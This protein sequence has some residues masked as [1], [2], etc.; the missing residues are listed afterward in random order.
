MSWRF[1]TAAVAA[2]SLVILPLSL[3][4]ANADDTPSEAPS[5][6]PSTPSTTATPSAGETSSAGETPA[7]TASSSP[8]PTESTASAP[9]TDESSDP[10]TQTLIVTFDKAQSDPAKAAEAAVAKVADQVADAQVAKVVPITDSIAAV[11][12][13]APLT[14]S[15]TTKVE[16]QVTDLKGVK[17]AEGAGW[18]RPTTTDDTYYNLLWNLSSSG[19]YGAHAE[20]AWST[21]TGANAVV[22]VIDTGITAHPD[23][24][25]SSS[26]I[27]GGNIIDGYDFITKSKVA[28][29]G[30][31]PDSNPSDPG[32]YTSQ[33]SSS[34][35]G[36]HVAG[37][38]AAI[39]NNHSGVAG[40]APDTKI[41]PL[42]VLGHGGG[43]EQD[44][45]T[46]ILWAAGISVANLPT[47]SQPVDVI[48]MSLGTTEACGVAMQAAINAATAKG[49]VVVVAAGN[50]A[51]PVSTSS[52]ANCNNVIS[53]AAT[54]PRGT[55]A[56][57]SNYGDSTRQ[58]TLS[59]P[60]GANSI[61]AADDILS[62]INL[63][64][65][66]PGSAGYAYMAGTSMAAPHVAGTVAL[67]K[68]IDPTLTYS[69][70]KYLLTESADPT[71][72]C[73]R[74]GA[75]RL[76]AAA[77]VRALA[78][79][80]TVTPS[81]AGLQAAAPQ[82]SGTVRVGQT[83]TAETTAGSEATLS[84]QWYRS[85][86]KI[87][88]ATGMSYLL[89]SS[90]KGKNMLVKVTANLDG[91]RSIRFSTETSS[92]AAGVFAKG[93]PSISGTYK[94]GHTLRAYKGTWSP[95]PSGYSYRWLRNGKSIS[96]ATK[97]KYKL[98]WRDRGKKISVKI[99]ASKSGYTTTSATSSSHSV[100]H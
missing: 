7:P 95:S 79:N 40:V 36:T 44:V 97:Y 57:Y 75:G 1:G 55:L 20:D 30:G 61:S 85:G 12:L 82:I 78:G 11:T 99:T 50:S 59:A 72:S 42:R 83:L 64:N 9:T 28:G 94:S 3:T 65:T 32:D 23:L 22:G 63:G 92:V 34:W 89:T 10:A 51:R 18:F 21:S 100:K 8:A 73:T 80:L 71:P 41:E 17:A 24:T 14:D 98:T 15:E 38:I 26:R 52:P 33:E 91:Q 29:D 54:G 88:G 5:A 37:I 74:C 68:S 93:T 90:D 45:I 2:L 62:T 35:H 84:Y 4:P 47:N 70:V 56:G 16:D 48:N 39:A 96:G 81:A 58:V 6:T 25:G 31:G 66:K 86:S 69:D 13:D 53:V 43:D 49:V 76:N 27:I 19:T 67:L 77:A 46:A 87:S 60:G